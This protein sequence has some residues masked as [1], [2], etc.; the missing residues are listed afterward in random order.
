MKSFFEITDKQLYSTLKEM[1][2]YYYGHDYNN[3]PTLKRL[4]R[5]EKTVFKYKRGNLT[6]K[7]RFIDLDKLFK[8]KKSPFYIHNKTEKQLPL[9]QMSLLSLMENRLFGNVKKDMPLS[10]RISDLEM[11]ILGTSTPGTL[12]ERFDYISERT[13]NKDQRCKNF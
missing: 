4:D 10:K 5:L 11:A 8:T 12:Q 7:Q 1:E 13:P 3:Q 6:W 9:S 2:T